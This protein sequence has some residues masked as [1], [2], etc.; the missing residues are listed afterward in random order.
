MKAG[1]GVLVSVVV[2]NHNRCELLQRCLLSLNRQSFRD[3]EVIVVDNGSTDSSPDMIRSLEGDMVDKG[4]YLPDNT[5]FTGGCNQGIRLAVGRYV[6]LI[7]NDAE[8]DS[9][10]LSSLLEV[11]LADP[12]SGMWASKILLHGKGL[13]DKVGHLIFPDGQN[14]GRGTGEIDQGQYQESEETLFPDGCAAL[15]RRE[16]LQELGGF[17]EDFFAYG[18]DADL[19]LRA[20]W[21]G[22]KCVYVP[23]AVVNHLHSSTTG[24]FD[25][26]KIYWV[27]RNRIWLACKNMPLPLLL[28]SPVFTLYRFSWNMAAALSGKG[29][30]GRFKAEHSWAR[31]CRVLGRA[32][33]DGWRGI[34]PQIRKRRKIMKTRKISTFSFLRLF[35]RFRISAR[36]LTMET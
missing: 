15:Y 27:E 14:R 30:A 7:N 10:W 31:L 18:D 32:T 6:A 5:G 1:E 13:I 22:W 3:F 29:A 20:R 25:P 24:S 21:R 2:V 19:G 34:V 8:A 23:S 4:I 28:M 11:A 35:L 33:W 9:E 36:K 17:D 26:R 16:L 12:S